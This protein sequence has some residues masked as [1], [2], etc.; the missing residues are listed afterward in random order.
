M[1]ITYNKSDLTFQC[2]HYQS[3]TKYLICRTIPEFCLD[4]MLQHCNNVMTSRAQNLNADTHEDE[5]WAVI[6][7][8]YR[9]YSWCFIVCK[10]SLLRKHRVNDA[11][12]KISCG[13]PPKFGK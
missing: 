13:S 2:I 10:M 1:Q 3:H 9:G 12:S 11:L 4:F 5:G 8:T 7:Q 6:M